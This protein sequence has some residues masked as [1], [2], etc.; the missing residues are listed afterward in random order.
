M[1]ELPKNLYRAEQ[2]RELDRIAIEQHGIAGMKLMERAGSAAFNLILS[3]C[4]RAKRIAVVCGTGNNGGDG[5]I[6][7]RMADA[8][9][10]RVMVYL[11]GDPAKLKGDA[12]TAYERLEG[13]HVG[14]IPYEEHSFEMFDVAV[15]AMLGTG[16]QGEVTG[17]YQQAIEAINQAK[18][19]GTSVM[20]VDIP[21]GLH[22]DTGQ[23]LGAAVHANMT[24]TFIG[25]KQGLLTAS[26]PDYCGHI[27]FNSLQVPKT[28]YADIR[29]SAQRIEADDFT[30][31]F[32]HRAPSTH[33][34]QCGHVVV[35]GG[36][37]GMTGAA[38]MAGEA[39]ARSGAGLVS[40]AT[41]PEHAQLINVHRP[42]LMCHGIAQK[43]DLL[44][45]LDKADVVA[46]GPGLGQDEWAHMLFETVM[47]S[48]LPLILDADGLNL[49]AE[50][51]RE[52]ANWVITP[53]PGE[54]ARLLQGSVQDV[55]NDRFYAAEQICQRYG[56]VC[57]LKGCGT[58]VSSGEEDMHLCDAGN[59]G[60]ASGG[61]GD[62]L[63]GIIAA[64]A[65][66]F[67]D[68][69]SAARAGVHV[70]ARAAD[71]AAAEGERGLLA[72]DLYAHIRG[73]INP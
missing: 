13:S 9:G 49:L 34:T 7:A 5:F 70:H 4:P 61:M 73:L 56:A 35:V 55:Q 52:R 66:Q 19:Q 68:L 63:T 58:L 57:V 46:L 59:P 14:I 24:M 25:M 62:V 18:A 42:E 43:S 39:A 26:G 48:N 28:V 2:V 17:A 29:P 47:Q 40:V 54:A 10:F 72:T 12:L 1:S 50:H 67:H 27:E 53:H 44:P 38:R 3:H 20:A 16:L 65:A 11:L 15:D 23:V 30:G 32:T 69:A 22:A 60:M 36:N 41:R 21:S 64:L 45:L 31:L 37:A 71:L 33:K 6:I 51:P 8:A